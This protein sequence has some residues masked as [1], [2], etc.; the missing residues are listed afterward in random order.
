MTEEIT[1]EQSDGPTRRRGRGPTRPFPSVTF[2]EA[3]RLPESIL[4]KGVNGE[5]ERLVLLGMLDV[6]PNSSKTRD[7]ITSSSKYGLTTGSFSA[8]FL[9]VTDDG[10]VAVDS[11]ELSRATKEKQFDL[12]I[13][14][15]SHF[16]ETYE[17]LKG[18]S[19]PDA[20]VLEGEFRRMGLPDSDCRKASEVLSENLRFLGLIQEIAG[21][22][23]V[24]DVTQMLD[25]AMSGT[26]QAPQELSNG[27]LTTKTIIPSVEEAEGS[28]SEPNRPALHIDIQVHIDSNASPDQIDQVFA[29]M[30]RHL[31]GRE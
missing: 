11:A 1:L 15:F 8:P 21:N 26:S 24:R 31:Y 3:I 7:W 6:S 5:I 14:Q 12:A 23:Y 10:R 22:D 30:A 9:A 4:D 27:D 16:S 19:L 20:A 25:D 18:K 2:E 28:T 13:G 29:S 17:R